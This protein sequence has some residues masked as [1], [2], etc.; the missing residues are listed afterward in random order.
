MYTKSNKKK[1]RAKESI[2]K[3]Q[4]LFR[5]PICGEAMG[6]NHAYSMICNSKHCFDLSKKGYLNLLTSRYKPVYSKELFEARHKVCEAGFYDPFIN[7]LAQIIGEY[8]KGKELNILDAGCGEGSH[9]YRLSQRI[10]KDARYTF[11]GVDISKDSIHI[12]ANNSS[13]IIW[14]I[15]D[16]A[17]LPFQNSSFDVLLNILSPANY[18]EFERVLSNSAIIIKVVPEPQYLKELRETIYNDRKDMHYSNNKVINYFSQRL[19]VM[20]IQ[21][22]SY[23]FAVDEKLLPYLIEMTPLTWGKSPERLNGIFEK[24]ISSIT[25]NLAIII[26]RKKK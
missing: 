25:V 3:N 15:A 10:E 6:M 22:I 1:D 20:D 8:Q 9:L 24:N 18:E 21:N 12:A 23:K 19:D 11:M 16:L 2:R 5:C 14:S 17:R 7:A 13:D 26:G 4:R